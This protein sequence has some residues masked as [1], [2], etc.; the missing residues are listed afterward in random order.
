MAANN[1]VKRST[2][3]ALALVLGACSGKKAEKKEGSQAPTVQQMPQPLPE[4]EAVNATNTDNERLT[5]FFSPTDNLEEEQVRHFTQAQR[6]IALECNRSRTL[7][8]E[9]L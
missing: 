6:S 4:A 1:L 2:L 9:K 5:S 7:R 8:E 3:I